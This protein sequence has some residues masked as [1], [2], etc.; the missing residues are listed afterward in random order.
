MYYHYKKGLFMYKKIILLLFLMIFILCGCS[1]PQKEPVVN[2]LDDITKRGEVV[3]G[4]KTDAYPFGFKDKNGKFAGYDVD[5]ANMIGQEIFKKKGKVKFVPVTSSDRIMKLFSEDVDMII[6][7]MSVTHSRLQ[8][9][10]FSNPYYIAGQAVMV[11]KGSKIKGLSDLNGKKV[12]IVFGT[13]SESSLRAAVPRVSILGYK[14]Y[15]EAVKALKQ[16][17]GDAI[18][19][20]DTIL[21]G[22]SLKDGNLVLLPKR[23]SREPYAVAFRK[24]IESEDL[25][26]VVNY[27]IDE[28]ARN[29]TLQKLQKNYGIKKY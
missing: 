26:R 3:I 28:S 4:I 23:Y 9:L 7:T 5:L 19:S 25:V 13:S 29:G 15:S 2:T 12:I 21:I 14:T 18:V 22:L 10:D 1:K 8:I 11:R 24:G 6:A 20:D 17:K 27:V 16:G